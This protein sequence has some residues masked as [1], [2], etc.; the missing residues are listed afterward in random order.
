MITS[1]FYDKG[2]IAHFHQIQ[3]KHGFEFDQPASEFHKKSYPGLWQEYEHKKQTD[4][5]RAE[6]Q[7]VEATSIGDGPIAIVIPPLTV[8]QLVDEGP[9]K[10]KKTWFQK[11]KG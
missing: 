8:Q 6:Q 11:K 7:K 2:G 5:I 4:L 3:D 1:K 9:P 10:G